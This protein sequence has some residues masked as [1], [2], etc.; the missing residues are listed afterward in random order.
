MNSREISE[1][2]RGHENVYILTHVLPDGDAIGSAL[3]W[4]TS[5]K[6]HG[7]KVRIFCPGVIPSKYAFLPE[8]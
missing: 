5:L 3:A 1:L 8:L 4:G 2:L 6:H 7:K